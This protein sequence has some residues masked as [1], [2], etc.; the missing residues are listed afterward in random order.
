MN[1]IPKFVAIESGGD[2]W[3]ASVEYLVLFENQSIDNLYD[4][5]FTEGAY[6]GTKLFFKAWILKNNYG[7]EADDRDF[8]LFYEK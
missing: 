6:F 3:D 4:K 1:N 5:Y 8:Q 7:R 2:W